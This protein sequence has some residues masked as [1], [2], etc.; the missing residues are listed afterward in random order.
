MLIDMQQN[1]N[2]LEFSMVPLILYSQ[3][4]HSAHVHSANYLA[5]KEGDYVFHLYFYNKAIFI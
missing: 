1:Q 2:N 3:A 4:V 5:E